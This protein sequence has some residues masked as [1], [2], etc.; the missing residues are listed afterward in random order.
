MQINGQIEIQVHRFEYVEKDRYKDKKNIYI[1]M[2]GHRDLQI[3]RRMQAFIKL[4]RNEDN[5]L[6]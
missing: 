1:Q 4:D 5:Y 2:G 3:D 6:N